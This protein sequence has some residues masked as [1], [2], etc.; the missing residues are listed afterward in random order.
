MEELLKTLRSQLESRQKTDMVQQQI[1]VL[2]RCLMLFVKFQTD[3]HQCCVHTVSAMIHRLAQLSD[4]A[5]GCDIIQEMNSLDILS[6]LSSR[7]LPSRGQLPMKPV[8]GNTSPKTSA[9][10]ST[11]KSSFLSLFDRK[12]SPDKAESANFY[13]DLPKYA[14]GQSASDSENL[15]P[16]AAALNVEQGFCPSQK[17]VPF[18]KQD[19]VLENHGFTNGHLASQEELDSVINL[20]SGIGTKMTQPMLTIPENQMQVN[21]PYYISSQTT[22]STDSDEFKAAQ[23][24]VHRRSE[25]SIDVTGVGTP[26]RNTWPHSHRGSLPAG[27]LGNQQY[28]H[29]FGVYSAFTPR[30]YSHDLNLPSKQSVTMPTTGSSQV[31]QGYQWGNPDS[32]MNRTWP[33]QNMNIPGSDTMGSSWSGFQDSDDLSDDSSSGEQFFAVGLDLVHVMDS[34][35]NSSIDQHSTDNSSTDQYGTDN[36]STDQKS[37]DNSSTDQKSTDNSSTDQYSTDNSN[38]DQYTT[39]NSST[40]QNSTDNSST[41]QYST[42]NSSTDQNSTDNSS[43]DQYSTDNSSTDQ[44]STDNSSTDQYSTDNSSTDQYSTDSSSTDQKS[45]DN[46]STDQYSTDSSSTDQYSTDNSSTDQYTTDNSSTDQYST[47]S[48]ST[49][50]YSTDNSS[51]DQNSTDNSS[52]DQLSTDNSSTDQYST[53]NS[54]TDQY[55]TDSSSTDQYSTDN[56]STDQNSTDNSSTDQNSTDNSSTDKTVQT[57]VALTSTVQTTVALTRKVQTTVALTSTVQTTARTDSTVPEACT[58]RQYRQQYRRT[59]TVHYRQTVA[60][61]DTDTAVALPVQ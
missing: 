13:I 35:T 24:A 60:L 28:P 27:P 16:G 3:F 34:S 50:Q 9:K 4:S 25:G 47:D 48:S 20:L 26:G 21:V 2:C 23:P 57:T 46:S 33:M 14:D 44:K 59:L 37:T 7:N 36:S 56:S 32:K 31:F 53:D 8:P 52:I 38:T 10:Q 41:D 45:T 15:V 17:D 49:D 6:F 43:T 12:N 54:S 39:D 51:T 58:A 22:P 11:L 29:D 5:G 55:S 19:E 18:K 40:D 61:T 1:Q 42:D 30:R